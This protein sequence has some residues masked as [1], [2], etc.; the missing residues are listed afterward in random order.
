MPDVLS[1]L[2]NVACGDTFMYIEE[3]HCTMQ[4]QIKKH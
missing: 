4:G 1:S 3:L 2:T